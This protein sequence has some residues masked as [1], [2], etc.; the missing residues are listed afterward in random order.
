V[1]A[2]AWDERK[3]PRETAGTPKGGQFAKRYHTA[4]SA[5][6]ESIERHGLD[7]RRRSTPE[8]REPGVTEAP[9][10]NYFHPDLETALADP[11]NREGWD[12]W[13]VEVDEAELEDDPE[14]K[15]EP[16]YRSSQYS[17][18]PVPRRRMRLVDR[19]GLTA[20]AAAWDP[21]KHPRHPAGTEQ[22]GEW[23]LKSGPVHRLVVETTENS[24][25]TDEYE[26][27]K[28][29]VEL[30]PDETAEQHAA[31]SYARMAVEY[32]YAHA[33]YGTAAMW[34]AYQD[35][36]LIGVGSGNFTEAGL[37][38]LGYAGARKQGGRAL[39]RQMLQ[40]AADSEVGMAWFSGTRQS[41]ELYERLGIP[42]GPEGEYVLDVEEVK[43][44]NK[45]MLAFAREK[46]KAPKSRAGKFVDPEDPITDAQRRA[47]G[48]ETDPMAASALVEPEWPEEWWL[49]P[50]LPEGFAA[51]AWDPAKHPR[52]PA[53]SSR[54]G[55]FA[56]KEGTF[57]VLEDSMRTVRRG[58]I[59]GFPAGV[60]SPDEDVK[61][62]PEEMGDRGGA[63]WKAW[64]DPN[65]GEELAFWFVTPMGGPHHLDMARELGIALP[66]SDE[67]LQGPLR[68]AGYGNKTDNEWL[69][70][71]FQTD[72]GMDAFEARRL[73]D[74]Q[75][76]EE[77]AFQRVKRFTDELPRK[78]R[79][80]I[81]DANEVIEEYWRNRQPLAA[82]ALSYDEEDLVA[83]EQK[84]R[85]Q[86]EKVIRRAARR[87]AADYRAATTVIRAAGQPQPEEVVKAAVLLESFLRLTGLARRNLLTEILGALGVLSRTQEDSFDPL[88]AYLE[89]LEAQ[90]GVQASRL[91]AGA[92]DAAADVMLTAMGEGWSVDQTATALQEKLESVAPWQAKMLAR[93][94]L[95]ALSNGASLQRAVV[96]DDPQLAYKTWLATADERTRID[97]RHAHGQ[98]VP[99]QQPFTVGGEQLLYPGDPAASDGNVINCRCT[100][101]YGPDPQGPV[102]IRQVRMVDLAVSAAGFDP[103]QP[104][105]PGGEGGGQ[106]VKGATPPAWWDEP[107]E[108]PFAK[109]RTKGEMLLDWL[110]RNEVAQDEEGRYIF[111]HATPK[112]GDFE[113]LRANSLL[114]TDPEKA[115]FFAARD[116]GL[117][118]DQVKVYEVR[119][120]PWEIGSASVWASLRD[121]HDLR[122]A[123]LLAAGWDESKH[124]RHPAGSSQGGEFAPRG[125]Y[126]GVM[127]ARDEGGNAIGWQAYRMRRGEGKYSDRGR[128]LVGP[129]RENHD[130]AFADAVSALEAEPAFDWSEAAREFDKWHDDMA[131]WYT[132]AEGF[133]PN[134]WEAKADETWIAY[135]DAVMVKGEEIRARLAFAGLTGAI[136]QPQ[137]NPGAGGDLDAILDPEVDYSPDFIISLPAAEGGLPPDF[138]VWTYPDGKIE[139]EDVLDITDTDFFPDGPDSQLATDYATALDKVRGIPDEPGFVTIYR[140]M[141][142]SE[143]DEW[144]SGAVISV[145]KF[146]AGIPTTQYAQDVSGQPPNLYSFKVPRHMLMQT[147]PNEYQ[148]KKRGK[149]R[150]GEILQAAAW[151]ESRHPRHPAGSERGGEFAPAND[152]DVLPAPSG[153]ELS[154]LRAELDRWPEETKSGDEHLV[155]AHAALDLFSRGEAEHYASGP[156]Q[157]HLITV[158]RD[159]DL[160]GIGDFS[161]NS[162]HDRVFGG[163]FGAIRGGGMD[164]FG[165]FLDS[166]PPGMG[167]KWTAGGPRSQALY[168]RLGI[169]S[170]GSMLYHLTADEVELL[171]RDMFALARTVRADGLLQAL[172][173]AGWV[174]SD[175]PRHPAGSTRGGEFRGAALLREIDRQRAERAKQLGRVAPEYD[176]H[177]K[178]MWS[179]D[180]DEF[181]FDPDDPFY[182]TP[183][184]K[185]MTLPDGSW[186]FWITD[187]RGF[188]H[189]D[190]VSRRLGVPMGKLYSGDSLRPQTNPPPEP[191]LL[192]LLSRHAH[193]WR[194]AAE[195]ASQNY[196]AAAAAPYTGEGGMVCLYPTPEEATAIARG[197]G[198]PAEDLHVTL[199]YFPDGVPA[200]AEGEI[201]DGDV[202]F[203]G[204]TGE[205]TGIARFAEGEDGVPVVALVSAPGLGT[206]RADL[207][208]ALPGY[209]ER[210]DFM[211]HITLGYGD[212]EDP[213][214]VLGL[215]VTFSAVLVKNKGQEPQAVLTAAGWDESKHPRHPA[216]DEKGGEF[217]PAGYTTTFEHGDDLR[218]WH[219][220]T[221]TEWE[222]YAA[223]GLY[224]EAIEGTLKPG[225]ITAYGDSVTAEQI[226]EMEDAARRIEKAASTHA[227]YNDDPQSS[228]FGVL[229]RGASFPDEASL[230]AAFPA[231]AEYVTKPLTATSTS[232]DAPRLYAYSGVDPADFDTDTFGVPVL[233]TFTSEDGIHMGVQ[234]APMGVPTNEVVMPGRQRYRVVTPP[235]QD[236]DGLW[237]V[238]LSR[239]ST[240]PKGTPVRKTYEGI[241]AAG[242]DE[243]EH[244]RWPAGDERGGEF[245]PK[246]A[247][248]VGTEA[249]L[250]GRK[251]DGSFRIPAAGKLRSWLQA[252]EGVLFP[253]TLA[254]WPHLSEAQGLRL[255]QFLESPAGQSRLAGKGLSAERREAS[256]VLNVLG[257][258]DELPVPITVAPPLETPDPPVEL[259]QQ[260]YKRSLLDTIT[261]GGG[262]NSGNML[263]AA[264]TID[265]TM[266]YP[267]VPGEPT[268]PVRGVSGGRQKQA[269][270]WRQTG[271]HIPAEI[272]LSSRAGNPISS[273][274][275]EFGHYLDSLLGQESWVRSYT[276]WPEEYSRLVQEYDSLNKAVNRA[277][278]RADRLD[279]DTGLSATEIRSR[280]RTTQELMQQ[281]GPRNTWNDYSSLSSTGALSPVVAAIRE[282]DMYHA[283]DNYVK[284]GTPMRGFEYG[285]RTFQPGRGHVRYLLNPPEL[286]ARSFE[287]YVAARNPGSK[288][289]RT[290]RHVFNTSP[291]YNDMPPEYPGYMK[292]EDLERVNAA[293]D[294]VLRQRGLLKAGVDR[295]E[296]ATARR[297]RELAAERQRQL[298]GR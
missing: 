60:F 125:F 254:D 86:Y 251:P 138:T 50:E 70:S 258:E 99:V 186:K 168:Q 56:G 133:P 9:P 134:F 14:G 228:E 114:E 7:Y 202:Q 185:A 53:G 126:H 180:A 281:V 118:R 29:K 127:M 15:Y 226:A 137:L 41:E 98:T 207:A 1:T 173:A 6:R 104:R 284:R 103:N 208:R 241:Q 112:N 275:H 291:G 190:A 210:H 48:G 69:Q 257:E 285:G 72:L 255:K 25:I 119:L 123:T 225:D 152:V 74:L 250:Q 95:V 10:A 96:L 287:Q 43:V 235:Q 233:I 171:R 259:P 83:A 295:N 201:I 230:L 240:I 222:D 158:R 216:G 109:G 11:P 88:S 197:G 52:H 252:Y 198:Q 167:A 273:M 63:A 220:V 191:E 172:V 272:T 64:V 249:R 196:L 140:G 27:I 149:L 45:D 237:R 30:W 94:D 160:I 47:W 292:G 65:T 101:I 142:D 289:A 161:V 239:A 227:V 181:I 179:A 184:W 32:A 97:H 145:G 194:A 87:A 26:R 144:D 232:K 204:L 212:V 236:E 192:E 269:T 256:W 89:I 51:A 177:L 170:T 12:V 107:H 205:I 132:E 129:V 164:L 44:L 238:T 66:T 183:V 20:S 234:T 76:R 67:V 122:R 219:G 135:Q 166:V 162:N 35:G 209:S 110:E 155:A 153:A 17:T 206:L 13:E 159:G 82:A 247:G 296:N 55:E 200:D 16:R 221:D 245:R 120:H 100:V 130:E 298:V 223:T 213:E 265:N 156:V 21:A 215:P 260:Q 268:I 136:I 39:F 280:I 165:T 163:S 187:R 267:K 81:S 274:V 151:D 217:A 37:L 141:T 58:E 61:F 79:K 262:R 282:T 113:F 203:E 214:G 189:H 4:R 68:V 248:L 264:R 31:K 131:S 193:K 80:D 42:R 263:E 218:E 54:G 143:F 150:D 278:G 59:Q 139:V 85:R 271:T 283:L 22:G 38:E 90:V 157:T 111:Y 71:Y 105:D 294:E 175:H 286:V 3:H 147:G 36:F 5:D 154:N 108:S 102:G 24:E 91:V 174:E 146:F 75:G 121:D 293:W 148:L 246:D 117:T 115:A 199:L 19:E 128:T 270:F 106:W 253:G 33:P 40:D 188:P 2:V 84:L 242:W 28:A 46:R 211:P 169:P 231:G 279:P 34:T 277:I 288:L 243:S 178:G 78:H 8:W 276:P 229:Y 224:N 297:E 73:A 176:E 195:R 261:I 57:A 290:T 23:A 116:R 266:H 182:T 92:Q 124:P 49:G 244:P 62:W 18:R 77:S 93:T